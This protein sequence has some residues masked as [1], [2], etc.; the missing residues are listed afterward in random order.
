VTATTSLGDSHRYRLDER[1]ATGGMGEVWRAT[2]TVLDREV[3]VKV[4]KREYADDPTFRSRFE[5]E[6]RHAAA[7]HH[8]GVASVF[9]FGEVSDDTGSGASCPFLVMELVPGQP[10]SMLLRGGEPMPPASAADLVAQAADAIAAAH[11]MDIVHRDV[12]PANLMVTPDGE[13]KITDF[14][15]ARAGDS[16]ALTGTGQVIGTPHYISPEQA[17][18][19]TATKASDVYSLGVV[20]Y[21][22]LAGRRPF[23]G[24]TP[25]TTALAHLREPAPPLPEHVPEQFRR[26]VDK[27]LAKD[28]AERFGSAADLAAA[29]RGGPFDDV[30]PATMNA[31]GVAAA[32]AAA[33]TTTGVGSDGTQVL[34]TTER[35]D[36]PDRRRVLPVWWPWAAAAVA[37]LLVVGLVNLLDGGDADNTADDNPTADPSV[38]QQ[39]AQDDRVRVRRAALVGLDADSAKD[40]LRALAL[41]VREE[42]RANP[43]G[44]VE[45]TVAA[46][47]PHGLVDPGSEITL[48]IWDKAE[49]ELPLVEESEGQ[50]DEGKG[51]DDGK[52]DEGPSDSGK[53]NSDKGKA[54]GNK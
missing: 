4:L 19:R 44:H 5:A 27:A 50:G 16:V 33:G 46:V 47:S 30:A 22:C 20:L 3:A 37:V 7:L 28:P 18:G 54:K 49:E 1:I 12:K 17:E 29:L 43:G 10:L 48:F 34:P 53:G 21:E 23:E 15:I 14:G 35:G 45:D 42:I 8:S 2:D 32:I 6:A 9:D 36:S 24:D 38:Q 25:V 39:A 40:Q 41:K 13:V 51:G 52:G 26:V 11:A 31:A